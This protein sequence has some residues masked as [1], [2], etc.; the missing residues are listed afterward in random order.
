LK[1]IFI[2]E[3]FVDNLGRFV[4]HSRWPLWSFRRS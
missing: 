3:N 1:G 4:N 2:G